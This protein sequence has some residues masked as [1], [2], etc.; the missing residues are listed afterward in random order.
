MMDLSDPLEGVTV[1]GR[2]RVL[3][4]LGAGATGSVYLAER[5]MLDRQVALKLLHE[6]Y[7][8]SVDFV[9][10]FER[11][12]RALSRLSHIH[13]TSILDFGVYE[14]RPYLVTELVRGEPLTVEIGRPEM[15]PVRA[16]ALVRQMLMGLRHAHEHGIVHR[17]LK[18]D[19]L[20]VTAL[21]GVG[22][23]L[24][25][26]DFGFAHVSDMRSQS[27]AD[28][29]PGTPSYMSPEQACGLRADGRSDLYSAG[30]ILYELCVGQRPFVA[31]DVLALLE[32]HKRV[33]PVP[34]RMAAAGR[35]VSE[36]LERV[37][38]RALTKDRDERFADASEFQ[39][40]LEA[41]PE[42]RQALLAS[43]RGA[44]AAERRRVVGYRV[45]AAAMAAVLVATVAVA[46]ASWRR[47][48]APAPA[49]AAAAAAPAEA[50][51]LTSPTGATAPTS[52]GT[53]AAA[54]SAM[55]A[56]AAPT[57]A[58]A[59]PAGAAPTNAVPAPAMPMIPPPSVPAAAASP[60]LPTST[61]PAAGKAPTSALG[62]TAV[63]AVA[64][65]A[66]AALPATPTRGPGTSAIPAVA[67]APVPSGATRAAVPGATTA[68]L[69]STPA[70]AAPREPTSATAIA[71]T[72][73]V[74]AAG[75]TT[76][77]H[78]AETIR[79]IRALIAA[80]R[81]VDA[82]R[83][84][85]AALAAAPR[86]A[87]L[88]FELGN[89]A[90]AQVWRKTALREWGEALRLRPELRHDP[91]LQRHLCTALDARSAAAAER[92]LVEAYGAG[93]V[94]VM[95]ACI[96]TTSDPEVLAAAVQVIEQAAGAG[97]VDASL[98]AR[99]E[100]ALARS[101]EE[102]KRAVEDLGR[103]RV[104]RAFDSLSAL[105]R[106]RAGERGVAGR[107]G[108]LGRSVQEALAQLR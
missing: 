45:A 24:K 17:D 83:A 36:A 39:S 98:V 91:L 93:V 63:S 50:A 27:N 85:N 61:M 10:R 103:L 56:G 18:P 89:L 54:T 67:T 4:A 35:G 86:D 25:I 59:M 107:H 100:L 90:F 9:R 38:L 105:E 64:S 104:R 77:A 3:C 62:T 80:G 87:G 37:I 97:K 57:N 49:I 44:H 31:D 51:K 88:H 26:V 52:A 29:V 40:A 32:M 96:R 42:G 12:A 92:V 72:P 21:E 15:T 41:T 71:P 102:R 95:N 99:R 30:V 33:E 58:A 78:S 20:M 66:N 43:M 69:V 74:A 6:H 65:A 11:E 73:A 79:A 7:A 94:G 13:C 28:L 23:V 5:V 16:V 101:C 48:E 84:L 68:S 47:P 19:N 76:P 14:G 108:C 1:D 81:L 106:E 82:E 8:G 75:A 60:A 2:W 46:F 22:E 34:P 70:A 55:P 53:T